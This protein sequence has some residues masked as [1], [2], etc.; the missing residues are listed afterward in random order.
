MPSVLTTADRD[1]LAAANEANVLEFFRFYAR[2]M[3][4][5]EILD[6]PDLFRAATGVMHPAMNGVFLTKL[7]PESADARI[8]E[9]YTYFASKGVPYMW[10]VGHETEPADLRARLEAAGL[11]SVYEMPGMAVEIDRLET[12]PVPETLEIVEALDARAMRDWTVPLCEAFGMPVEIAD[13]IVRAHERIGYG[14][15]LPSRNYLGLEAGRPV[16][17]TSLFMGAGVAGI[18][19]VG[20]VPH[21]RGKGYA[22][23]LVSHTL[24]QATAEGYRYGTLQSS[25]MGYRVYRRMGFHD[26]STIGLFT[27]PSRTEGT[28]S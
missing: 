4:R 17:C 6:A 18:Y 22:S 8:A 7:A 23:A 14:A 1:S 2:H 28:S 20:T 9:T 11:A 25:E 21:A 19:C 24:R 12:V 5:A 13:P 3:E 27:V 15:P 26:V 16:A 10:W